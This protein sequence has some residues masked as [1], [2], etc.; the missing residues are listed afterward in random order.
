MRH[1]AALLR[2]QCFTR[3]EVAALTGSGAAADSVG[4]CVSHRS[5]FEHHGIASQI[6]DEACV[7][8]ASHFAGRNPSIL[9]L[10][11]CGRVGHGQVVM[12]V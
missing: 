12:S 3:V 9:K 1:C 5:A 7:S 8:T 6:F 4:A 10:H 2:L 11:I